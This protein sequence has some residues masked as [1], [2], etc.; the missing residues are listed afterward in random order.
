[1]NRP[2]SIIAFER[3]YLGS[4]VLSIINA[5]A[6]WSFNRDAI[7]A[8][9]QVQESPGLAALINIM[10]IVSLAIT[11]AV[12]LLFWWLVARAGSVVGKWLVIVTEGLGVLFA[13]VPLLNLVRGHAAN[14]P[15]TV[16]TL[17]CTALAVA[18][19]AM[20][21]RADVDAWIAARENEEA[22]VV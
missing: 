5:I 19:A 15:G 8:M 17:V 10:L 16:V 12:S 4:I 22:R 9:P 2:P 13:I 3:L 20:L 14:V 21:F 6:F 18:A 7:A 11:V 1:M